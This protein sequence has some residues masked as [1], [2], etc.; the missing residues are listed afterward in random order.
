MVRGLD[1]LH[2]ENKIHRDIKGM[3]TKSLLSSLI[4]AANILLSSQGDVKIADFGVAA[5]LTNQKNKRN[6]FVGTPY[7]VSFDI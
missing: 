1:Y 5:Q 7:W 2:G 3:L 6:T 4:Q